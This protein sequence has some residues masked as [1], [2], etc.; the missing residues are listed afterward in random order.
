MHLFQEKGRCIAPWKSSL[1]LDR[2]KGGIEEDRS[3]R[4][5]SVNPWRFVELILSVCFDIS[6][7]AVELCSKFRYSLQ[8]TFPD[9]EWNMKHMKHTYVI[10]L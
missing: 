8:K 9:S 5:H 4:T 1:L 6:V 3:T 10:S 2:D 7:L